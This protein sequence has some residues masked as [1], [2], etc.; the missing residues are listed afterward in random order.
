MD[1]PYTI[2]STL[3][4]IRELSSGRL[5]LLFGTD[6]ERGWG[7]KN[8]L[9]RFEREILPAVESI[10]KEL[11]VSLCWPNR[12]G[13][14]SPSELARFLKARG[15]RG[16]GCYLFR[17]DELIAH[18]MLRWFQCTPKHYT[19]AA[20][21]LLDDAGRDVIPESDAVGSCRSPASFDPDTARTQLSEQK[22]REKPRLPLWFAVLSAMVAL[23]LIVA[24]GTGIIK[25]D[26]SLISFSLGAAL[27]VGRDG[28]VGAIIAGIIG[29]VFGKSRLFA[30]FGTFGGGIIG[31]VRW[32][33]LL[34]RHIP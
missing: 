11:G 30:A 34:E 7:E 15:L 29:L 19:A 23:V 32:I 16:E 5:V 17:D 18:K 24:G 26:P 28:I 31:F 20:R 14:F 27:S 21:K 8:A 10:A 12:G 3:H 2:V 13:I 1:R 22:L 4:E 25:N 6:A 9:K 33:Q